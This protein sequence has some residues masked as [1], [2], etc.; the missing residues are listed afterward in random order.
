VIITQGTKLHLLDSFGSTQSAGTASHVV[1]DSQDSAKVAAV[2]ETL[3]QSQYNLILQTLNKSYWRI[4]GPYGAAAALKVHPSKLR[5]LMKKLGIT[6][7]KMK[8][9]GTNNP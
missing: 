7:P 2:G 8:A 3:E 1:S 9:Q 5:A 6:R 4:E